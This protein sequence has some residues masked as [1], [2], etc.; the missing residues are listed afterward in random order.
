[1]KQYLDQTTPADYNRLK[2]KRGI[3]N[4]TLR[5]HELAWARD[6]RCWVIP[7]K[8]AKGHIF[9]LMRYFPDRPKP[10]K[11]MLPGLPTALYGFD[12]LVAADKNKIVFLCEG[13]FDAI[14]LDYNISALKRAKYVIVGI[15]GTFKKEWAQYFKHRKVRA[16]FDNDDGGEAHRQRVIILL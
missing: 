9:N 14:A 2:A 10:N 4:Q 8:N 7:F 15:P 1:H 16:L 5:L 13:P 3:A 6:L 11:F 12:K